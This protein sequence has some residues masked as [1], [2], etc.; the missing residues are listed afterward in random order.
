LEGALHDRSRLATQRLAAVIA[1][2]FARYPAAAD[3][4]KG[5]A[6]WW[7]PE[8]GLV[9]TTAQV[10]KALALLHDRG[11][12]VRRRLP[13]GTAIYG[14][15]GPVPAWT[16]EPMAN[17]QAVHS[18]A[19][20]IVTF[21]NNT[22]PSQVGGVN[23][24]ECEFALLS[25]GE[26]AGTITD[27]TR[28]T[29]YL[30]RMTVNEHTRQQR[31]SPMSSAQ[32]APLGLDLHFLVTA[33]GATAQAE[34]IPLT[35]A[36]RQLYLHPIL[37]ASSLTPE[38]GWGPDEVIQ[39]IPAELPTEDMMRIWDALEPAYRLSVSYIARMVRIDPDA[40]V[41]ATPVVATRLGFGTAA[42]AG[43]P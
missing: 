37:D 26:L 11:V 29:L 20:S 38:A 27:T 8:F 21:L 23:T 7:L 12:V 30:Y 36:M 5:I 4:E 41:D 31:P 3:D 39:I 22:Y 34:Q 35:W 1:K 14:R 43:T 15:T 33:W 42:P 32:P 17:F 13:G 25:S 2:H 16:G 19:N 40:I 10:R 24:P 9:A 18:V 6:E 28:V